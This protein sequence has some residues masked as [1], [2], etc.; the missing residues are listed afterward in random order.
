MNLGFKE[1]IN[2]TITTLKFGAK[3]TREEFMKSLKITLLGIIII[4]LVTF[5]LR[6]IALAL[7]SI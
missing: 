5:V 1:F 6:F 4:G 2:S 7:Q 3:R